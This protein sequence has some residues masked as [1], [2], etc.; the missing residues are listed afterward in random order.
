MVVYDAEG[1]RLA[2]RVWLT[3]WASGHERVAILN[4]GL[5]KWRDEAREVT[6]D[7][8]PAREGAWQPLQTPRNVLGLEDVAR[9]RPHATPG[10]MPASTL[11]D[12]RTYQEFM[13]ADVRAK[14][15]GHIPGAVNLPFDAFLEAVSP[16]QADPNSKEQ[17]YHV[18]RS[19]QEIHGILRAA[20]VRPGQPL[21]VYCQSGGRAAHLQFSLLLMGFADTANYMGSWREYG[22]RDDVD[23]EK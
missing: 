7:P 17:P 10:E 15:G 19:P 16:K 12:A 22:N 1:G 14:H 9:F 11:L 13:G 20:C 2:A 23:I 6:R 21:A 5:N 4:G 18:W 3:I 8:P